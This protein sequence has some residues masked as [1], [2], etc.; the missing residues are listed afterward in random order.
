MN[1]RFR[2]LVFAGVALLLIWLL[3]WA[4]FVISRNS[5]MT[6]EKVQA[7]LAGND[8]GKLSGAKRADA[9]RELAD[10]LNALSIEERRKARA[11]R[12]WSDWFRQMTD[13]EKTEF[14]EATM[15]TGFKQMLTAFEELPEDKRRKTIDDSIKRMR[16][17]REKVDS[18]QASNRRRGNNDSAM[19]E[20][21]HQR[22]AEIGLKTFYTESSA[23]TKAE[24]APLMEEIQRSMES[25]RMFR[26]RHGD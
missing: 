11:D 24:L 4:G 12:L 16:E 7:Y 23:Q 2:P 3:A 19:S 8:L 15:P 6:A 17:E 14:I 1:S 25:G 22:V 13:E 9:I 5:K 26:R 20:E 21:M 10:K 18:E